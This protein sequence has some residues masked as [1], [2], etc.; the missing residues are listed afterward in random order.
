[1]YFVTI[2]SNS[3]PTGFINDISNSN[4]DSEYIKNS[5]EIDFGATNSDD[6]D[7]SESNPLSSISRLNKPYKVPKKKKKIKELKIKLK[8]KNILNSTITTN[9]TQKSTRYLIFS[10]IFLYYFFILI[11][12]TIC[13]IFRSESS[14]HKRK[15]PN[16]RSFL[17]STC[18][19]GYYKQNHLDKH[20][21]THT[22][23]SF[24][25]KFTNL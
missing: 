7:D 16:E 1:M 15:S 2:L 6:D 9:S 3:N 17:C 13:F 10:N 21:K 20:L 19:K 24:S 12:L 23:I 14:P 4:I 8:K 22:V 11:C 18:G 5:P 25:L